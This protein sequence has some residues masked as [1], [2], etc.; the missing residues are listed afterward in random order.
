MGQSEETKIALVQQ[1][2]SSMK[3]MFSE[4]SEAIKELTATLKQE[5]VTHQQ[6]KPVENL[7]YWALK[8]FVGSLV[9]AALAAVYKLIFK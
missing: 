9:G 7:V 6:F 4:L 5:Y 2:L 1:E 8:I 3:N